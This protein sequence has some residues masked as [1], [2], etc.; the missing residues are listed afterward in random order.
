MLLTVVTALAVGVADS[1]IAEA[2]RTPDERRIAA[3]AADHLVAPDGPLADR[4]NVLNGSRVD[5]FDA[6]MLRRTVPPADEHAVRV[7]LDGTALANSGDP[8][9]GTTIRRLV[10]VERPVRERLEADGTTV[11]LPRRVGNARVAITPPADTA[12][13]TVRDR[14]SVRLHNESGLRGTFTLALSPYRTTRLQ[15]QTAGELPDGSVTVT[16][17]AP[18]TRKATLAVTVDA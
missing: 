17:D 14:D 12:I 4:R 3:A 9:G 16:Y 6:G 2:D 13:W 18:R 7:S 11:T 8:T 1:A 10:L 5:D 15:F